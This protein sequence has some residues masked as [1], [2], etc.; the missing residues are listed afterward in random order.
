MKRYRRTDRLNTLLREELS[1]LVRTELK[2]PRVRTAPVTE[3]V[4]TPDLSP[5]PVYVRTLDATVTPDEAIRGLESA[6]GFLR[7]ALGRELH[8]RKI[9]EFHFT[10]DETLERAGR[11]EALLDEARRDG[12]GADDG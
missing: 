8:I 4:T 11:I 2:D 10:V 7:H 5:A 6:Q 12:G 9:P 3:V 1:R